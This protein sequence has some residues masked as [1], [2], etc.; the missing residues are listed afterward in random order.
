MRLITTDDLLAT[1]AVTTTPGGFEAPTLDLPHGGVFGGQ[2]LAQAVVGAA[3]AR[4]D[5]FVKSL[6]ARFPREAKAERR[7][8]FDV[9]DVHDGRAMG[10]AQ[11]DGVQGGRT[12]FTCQLTL[13]VPEQGALDHQAA[14]PSVGEPGDAAA[15]ELSMIPWECRFVGDV[16]LASRDTGPP[17]LQWWSRLDRR[18]NDD[19]ALHQALLANATD[20]TLIGTML[21][22]HPWGEA[23]AHVRVQTAVTAHHLWYHRPFRVDDWL[24]IDQTSPVLAGARGFGEGR[25]FDADGA[26]VASFAQESLIR[27][28]A[29]GSEDVE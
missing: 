14:P 5:K 24:L 8:E 23:D 20:L 10:T 27:P 7:L 22:P 9:S 13:H 6:S 26:L 15:V 2:L 28:P 11:I 18:L 17:R 3:A 19:H 21:R 29:E 16:D 25:V 1:L 4:P 12:F